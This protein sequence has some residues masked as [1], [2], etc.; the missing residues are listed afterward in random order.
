MTIAH[1]ILILVIF[2][3]WCYFGLVWL[4]TPNHWRL[5]RAITLG[6]IRWVLLFV[7]RSILYC[8]SIDVEGL[9]ISTTVERAL[10]YLLYSHSLDRIVRH[11][12]PHA[13]SMAWSERIHLGTVG[14]IPEME[15]PWD[16]LTLALESPKSF[17][18]QTLFRAMSS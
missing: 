10:V 17:L 15:I 2:A 4:E 13:I 18:W 3:I 16:L 1:Q 14:T 8:A 6:S 7:F 12:Q 9:P 5:I 11:C